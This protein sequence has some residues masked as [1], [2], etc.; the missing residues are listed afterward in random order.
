MELPSPISPTVNLFPTH[1]KS[2]DHQISDL[3]DSEQLLAPDGVIRPLQRLDDLRQAVSNMPYVKYPEEASP[4]TEPVFKNSQD[5]IETIETLKAELDAPEQALTVSVADPAVRDATAPLLI[6]VG[7]E[8][9]A[10][11]FD[12][13]SEPPSAL[14]ESQALGHTDEW[15][16][17]VVGSYL[18]LITSAGSSNSRAFAD[19][20]SSPV[21]LTRILSSKIQTCLHRDRKQS[22]GPLEAMGL[23]GN[24]KV[25]KME[26]AP[27]FLTVQ[28]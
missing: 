2:Q 4:T 14:E 13:G 12:E 19:L 18:K 21:N 5:L 28:D 20:L 24:C 26:L 1:E 11:T 9:S 22:E 3:V 6:S 7:S 27:L 23:A 8:P 16:P 25:C 10:F 15:V 17:Y